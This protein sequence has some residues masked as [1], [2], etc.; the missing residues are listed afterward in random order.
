M[1]PLRACQPSISTALLYAELFNNHNG[2]AVKEM[3]P[4]AVISGFNAFKRVGPLLEFK[5]N[6]PTGVLSEFETVLFFV[7]CDFR[8][9]M[10]AT[11]IIFSE[12]AQLETMV[13]NVSGML[14]SSIS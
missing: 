3:S 5:L 12:Q 9:R 10:L 6:F 4:A 1:P 2:A 14:Y 8:L 13:C 7:I 11:V